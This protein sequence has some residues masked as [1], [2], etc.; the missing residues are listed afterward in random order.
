MKA[1][2]LTLAMVMGQSVVAADMEPLL[3]DPIVEKA[4]RD[5]LKTTPRRTHQG[6]FGGGDGA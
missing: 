5:S 3:A 6:G 1:T 4:I 2:L